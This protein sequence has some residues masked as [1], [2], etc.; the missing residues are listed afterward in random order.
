MA[1][2]NI[3]E[4]FLWFD[5]KVK[6]KQYPNA[7]QLAAEFEISLK[8][9]QGDIEFMRDRLN[10]P[11]LYQQSRKGYSYREET[12]ALPS[13]YISSE[14]LTAL[15]ITRKMLQGISAECL[16]GELS[17]LIDKI[18]SI[19]KK[20]MIEEETIDDSVSIRLIGYAIP[21]GETFKAVLEGCLKKKSISFSYYS[22]SRSETSTRN[23]NPYH[24]FNYMG[25]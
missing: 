17:L 10:C 25:T 22:A 14:E 4:R 20:H 3:Y 16:G 12:F 1:K 18:T 24:L 2:K 9:A 15:L 5:Q 7:S 21:S 6:A 11:L 23:V 13:I 19:L 8:T